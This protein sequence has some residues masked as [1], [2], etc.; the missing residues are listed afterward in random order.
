ML[1]NNSS[2]FVSQAWK[3][4]F[5]AW[6]RFLKSGRGRLMH[7]AWVGKRHLIQKQQWL[8]EIFKEFPLI[9]YRKRKSLKDL[10]SARV[11]CCDCRCQVLK[12]VTWDASKLIPCPTKEVPRDQRRLQS[13]SW[14]KFKKSNNFFLLVDISLP[15][16]IFAPISPSSLFNTSPLFLECY[17][18]LF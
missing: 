2:G 13:T 7:N 4:V 5:D 18:L 14:P 8:R 9:S 6:D 15:P 3:I 12:L 1:E 16:Y 17:S 10:F 11:V